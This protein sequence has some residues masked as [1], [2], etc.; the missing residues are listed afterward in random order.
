MNNAKSSNRY[1]GTAGRGK[2]LDPVEKSA[3]TEQQLEAYDK[4]WMTVFDEQAYSEG[5]YIKGK[6][7]GRA[8]E[9]LDNARKMKQLGANAEF[10]AQ[11]TGLTLE[12]IKNL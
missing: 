12:E 11:V 6:A 8:E 4:F 5:R 9:K 2:Y 1:H 3:M 7:E 10:I